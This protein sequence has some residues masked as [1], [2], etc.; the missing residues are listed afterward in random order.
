[1]NF[2]IFLYCFHYYYCYLLLNDYFL[3]EIFN[4]LFRKFFSIIIN[5]FK[6]FIT[7]SSIDLINSLFKSSTAANT[8]VNIGLIAFALAVLFQVVTLPV[9]YNAS[10]RAREQLYNLG[11]ITAEERDA[12]KAVLSA[13]ALTYVA[14]ALSSALSL[15]RL[16]LLSGGRNRR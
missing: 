1:M 9:E 2:Y 10:K 4:F 12:V 14:S 7:G 11:L 8:F 6:R 5:R 16:I 13:A 3:N 15:F